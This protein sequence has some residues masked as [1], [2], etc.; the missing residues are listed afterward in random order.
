MVAKLQV[1]IASILA[2]FDLAVESHSAKF[3]KISGYTVLIIV[4]VRLD[5]L[6]GTEF[7]V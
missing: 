3:N 1:A 7:T 4:L 2:G 5:K 6:A